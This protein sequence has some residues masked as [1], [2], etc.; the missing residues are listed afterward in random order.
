MVVSKDHILI[1]EN[2]PFIS[3]FIGRQVLSSAGYR[4][5][6]VPDVNTAISKAKKIGPDLIIT[7][8]NLPGLSGKD[9]L[10]ALNSQG[11]NTPVIV[12]SSK[13]QEPE[14][15]Q[16]FR[17][18]AVDYI[19]WPAKEP[20]IIQSVE[21][22]IQQVHERR[23]RYALERKL[24]DMNQQLQKR[25][26]ELTA[27]FSM[28]KAV[29]S[30]TDQNILFEKINHVAAQVTMA[31]FSWFLL[32]EEKKEKQYF[33]V[34]QNNLPD[35]MAD[36][37]HQ[38]WDDGISS[39]VAMSGE[40]LNIHGDPIKRFPIKTIGN[41][42]LIVPVKVQRQVIGLLV[43]M[44]KKPVMFTKSEQNLLEA[45][46][47]YASISLANA[48]LFRA[49]EARASALEEL[50]KKSQTNER[51]S[52]EII[53]SLNIKLNEVTETI[54]SDLDR[55]R[56]DPSVTWDENQ[57]ILF[58]RLK[59]SILSY[60]DMSATLS[61]D[62]SD[63]TGENGQFVDLTTLAKLIFQKFQPLTKHYNLKFNLMVPEQA[64]YIKCERLHV[65]EILRGLLTNAIQF[66]QSDGKISLHINYSSPSQAQFSVSNSG[67]ISSAKKENIFRR[68][69]ERKKEIFRFGGIGISLSLINE[70][71]QIYNG[72][73]W[74]DQNDEPGT[75][76]NVSLPAITVT[77]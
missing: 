5:F 54:R 56:N 19:N 45:V 35:H 66:C 17:L 53:K 2:D 44:R 8:I 3:D 23:Q 7:N 62:L 27:I 15:I 57:Q 64:V 52:R 74:I 31:D 32:R 10:V 55:L 28:G 9:L 76:F 46:A 41:S 77:T 20:E 67:T 61:T 1:V 51:I 38:T 39:L 21:R 29:T 43:V 16:T 13:G 73:I 49:I 24:K 30:I 42:I 22:I 48:R 36:Y 60:A 72:K 65:L 70:I 18:G 37:L 40:S 14:V 69:P 63:L 12:I 75:I 50:A 25:V 6:V 4:V 33:L 68:Q 34:A 11:I 26:R 71:L 58:E 47:D 59:N